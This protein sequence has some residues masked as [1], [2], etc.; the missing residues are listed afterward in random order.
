MTHQLINR[1]NKYSTVSTNLSCLSTKHVLEGLNN[2]ISLHQGIGGT[3]TLI[4][5]N[6]VPV[7][8]K[9]IPIA[10]LECSPEYFMSTANIFNLPLFYQYGVGSAGFGVWRE[11]AA[12]VMTTNWVLTNKCTYFP[13]MYHWRIIPQAPCDSN[14]SDWDN[15]ES[16]IHYWEGNVAIR[17]R[18]EQIHH[19]TNTLVLFL[20]YVPQNLFD[21]LRQHISLGG[22]QAA[23]A[24]Q[25]VERNLKMSNQFMN[26]QGL[27]HFDAHF[28]NILTDGEQLYYSDFGLALSSHFELTPAEIAFLNL[29][30][31]YDEACMAVNLLHSIVTAF[32]GDDKQWAMQIK[33]VL[34]EKRSKKEMASE[35]KNVI[36][37]Y[38]AIAMVMDEFFQKLQKES[39]ET[40][41]P[42]EKI[43]SLLKEII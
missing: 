20:E 34:T 14:I 12:H 29:H 2:G 24:V 9:K 22:A 39:K 35:I 37:R 3:S 1:L 27:V 17:H 5:I 32:Y 7:F 10:E 11:L 19:A 6:E 8:V 16:Y 42:T 33:K 4:Q 43:S 38:G 31:N 40:S 15:L 13:L 41:Y 21:W 23:S 30:H 25:F 26:A 36:E 28:H 18:M